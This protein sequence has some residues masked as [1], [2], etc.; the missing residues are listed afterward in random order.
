L[1]YSILLF[2]VSLLPT[3]IGISG[4]IYFYGALLLGFLM[5]IPGLSMRATGS[6]EDARKLLKASVLYLPLLLILIVAD[7]RW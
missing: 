4:P 2:P 3:L 7:G 1:V 6:L 5:L